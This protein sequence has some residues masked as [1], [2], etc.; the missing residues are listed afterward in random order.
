MVV[1]AL[2]APQEGEREALASVLPDA[3]W[4]ADGID[5]ARVRLALTFFPRR[6]MKALGCTWSV[7]T[8]L[9]AIQACTAGL[10]HMGWDDLPD[11]PVGSTP[12]GTAQP[13][14][15]Y[16]LACILEWARGLRF[17]T[18]AIK[19]G[20]FRLGA[21]VRSLASLRV[22]LVG[23]G[24]IGRAT[25]ELLQGFGCTVEAVSRSRPEDERLA[26]AGTLA[27]RSEMM[28]RCDVTVVCLPLTAQTEGLLGL[29]ELAAMP[30]SSLLIN[31]AR[32]PIVD[33]GAL[34]AWLDQSRHHR[35]ALDV[36]WQY[37]SQ[38]RPFEMP[39]ERLENVI[40]TPH[41]SPNV[42]GFRLDMIRA[43]GR[44]VQTWSQ[45]GRLPSAHERS[46]YQTRQAGD[47]R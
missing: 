38:G 35:A 13:I 31:V 40:M 1:A 28:G 15:E 33:E 44:H 7:F 21:P 12:G 42:E 30:R 8:H 32:G 47:G 26:W 5:P 27:D 4:M 34:F 14:S 39:F 6:E 22:G 41:N 17:H 45:T 16:V 36:W 25:L 20:D 19:K 37:P 46:W 29:D 2:W 3:V 43:A 24:G 23:F 9:E 10:N 11:V 18:E